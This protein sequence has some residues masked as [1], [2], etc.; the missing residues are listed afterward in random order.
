MPTRRETPLT[1]VDD[2]VRIEHLDDQLGGHE[3]KG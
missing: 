1:P 3:E 2:E